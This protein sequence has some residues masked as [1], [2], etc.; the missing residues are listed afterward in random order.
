MERSAIADFWRITLSQ[1][2]SEIG[3]LAYLASL[4]HPHTG[5][6]HHAGFEQRYGSLLA[7]EAIRC[8]HERVFRFWLTLSLVDQRE[9][10]QLYWSGLLE[11]RMIVLKAWQSGQPYLAWIPFAASPAERKN[12]ALHMT[13][14][15]SWIS[16]LSDDVEAQE[17]WPPPQSDR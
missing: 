16:S 17:D 2:P 5:S 8:S 11:K 14:I 6:Y 10:C 4:R 1:I 12:F 9:D 15:L 13:T 7:D 3:K